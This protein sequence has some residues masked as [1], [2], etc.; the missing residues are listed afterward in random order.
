MN[1]R[2]VQ[3]AAQR[4]I[5]RPATHQAGRAD[6]CQAGNALRCLHGRARCE[7]ARQRYRQ[8]IDG[9]IAMADSDGG[10]HR[11]DSVSHQAGRV[12]AVRTLRKTKAWQLHGYHHALRAIGAK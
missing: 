2:L 1:A 5:A 7:L 11:M 3:G 12:Q 6:Q 8:H 9:A 10:K 4:R